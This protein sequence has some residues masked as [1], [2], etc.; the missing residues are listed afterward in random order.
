MN[1]QNIITTNCIPLILNT[2]VEGLT[3]YEIAM[4]QGYVGTEAEWLQTLVQPAEDAQA[5]ANALMIEFQ[6]AENL[7]DEAELERIRLEDIRKTNE[8]ER[9]RLEDLRIDAEADRNTAE[10]DR[11]S[12]EVVIIQD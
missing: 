7:R 1:D 9:I 6:T 12:N 4:K 8:T 2:G 11:L 10:I 5:D 3:A